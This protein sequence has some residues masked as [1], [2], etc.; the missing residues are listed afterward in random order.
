MQ[1]A[2]N[3]TY[4]VWVAVTRK[5]QAKVGGNLGAR[6]VAT[7]LWEDKEGKTHATT[8]WSV[9]NVS[10]G[11]SERRIWSAV[12]DSC[13]KIFWLY[14]EREP[15]SGGAG[16]NCG[17]F[18]RDELFEAFGKFPVYWTYPY[19]NQAMKTF[20]SGLATPI[21]ML[22]QD[23]ATETNN[24]FN[25]VLKQTDENIRKAYESDPKGNAIKVWLKEQKQEF[26]KNGVIVD[27]EADKPP[28]DL[29]WLAS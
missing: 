28:T 21:G 20:E 7:L 22:A 1:V 14:T 29:E 11:H 16:N 5:R 26:K 8:R 10:Y 19:P 9:P 25:K 13:A 23:A 2:A 18:I 15:C 4:A 27:V 24:K 17:G 12:K 3:S 6:N